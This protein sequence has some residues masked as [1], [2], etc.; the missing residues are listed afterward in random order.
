MKLKEHLCADKSE[1]KKNRLCPE[2]G[3][4]FILQLVVKSELWKVSVIRVTGYSAIVQRAGQI[5]GEGHQRDP[6]YRALLPCWI[7]EVIMGVWH[8]GGTDEENLH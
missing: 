5:S 3:V 8:K 1:A 2:C 6:R 4:D 7:C